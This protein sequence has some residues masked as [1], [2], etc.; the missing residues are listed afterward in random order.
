MPKGKTLKLF[1]GNANRPLV[2]RVA[3]ILDQPVRIAA[4]RFKGGEVRVELPEDVRGCHVVVLQPTNEPE[5]NLKELKLMVYA[6]RSSSAAYVTAVMPHFGYGRQDRR[7]RP[8]VPI[9]ARMVADEIVAAG[10][11]HVVLLDLHSATVA[12]FFDPCKC[13]VDHLYGRPVFIGALRYLGLGHVMCGTPDVGRA[14]VA[15]SYLRRFQSGIFFV[16]KGDDLQREGSTFLIGDV[17]GKDCLLIDDEIATGGTIC[18]AAA[19]LRKAGA[20][21]ISVVASH[22]KCIEDEDANAHASVVLSASPVDRF[23]LGDSVLI[24]S[25]CVEALGARLTRVTFAPL[26]GEAI[27][28]IH[29]DESISALFG[30]ELV[31]SLYGDRYIVEPS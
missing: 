19:L 1:T 13:N 7:D 30:D 18:D 11:N 26:L 31:A 2:E 24:P 23:F 16:V 15:Q 9:S 12:G 25:A 17:D 29:D 27:K 6:A 21:T 20:K 10:A 5:T 3:A 28:H 14:K 8:R 22:G 4:G